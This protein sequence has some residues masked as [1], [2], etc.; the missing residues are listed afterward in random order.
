MRQQTSMV[1]APSWLPLQATTL[2]PPVVLDFKSLYPSIMMAHNL[3]YSTLVSQAMWDY[4]NTHKKDYFEI[5]VTYSHST[6]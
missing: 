4:I 2:T 6:T 1:G 5:N 3:C